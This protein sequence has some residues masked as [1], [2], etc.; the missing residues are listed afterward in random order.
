FADLTGDKFYAHTDPD[1]AARS[2]FGEIVAHGYFVLSAAAGLFVHPDE[3]PVMLNY[4]LESLRFIAPVVPGDTIQAKLIVKRKSVRQ[5]KAKD[6]FPFGIVYWDVEVTNQ[7][8]ELVAEYT[9][10]TLIKRREVLDMDI[11]E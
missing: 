4:G 5:K 11:F 6:K 2:L 9:I 1:A 3:G 8:E 10:L 7:R